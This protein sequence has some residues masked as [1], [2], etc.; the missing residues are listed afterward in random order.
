MQKL[1]QT[2][3]FQ[4]SFCFLKKLQIRSKQLVCTFVLI[5]FH[6]PLAGHKIKENFVKFQTANPEIF[7]ISISH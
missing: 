5:H 7:S 4:N 3:Q 2:E 6:R 1:R